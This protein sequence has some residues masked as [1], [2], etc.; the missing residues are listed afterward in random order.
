MTHWLSRTPLE[1]HQLGTRLAKILAP[2][3]TLLLE[4]ELGSGKT[5][6]VQGLAA[7]LGLD[8]QQVQSPTF[9]LIREHGSGD[10]RLIHVDLYRLEAS[11]TAALGLEEILVGPGVK[12][13]EW[14]ERLTFPV[15]GAVRLRLERNED[16]DRVIYREDEK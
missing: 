16:G 9:T 6:L 12:A 14:A 15:P 8:P 4:G 7:G 2:G 5:V 10:R 11:E 3:G 1:T 13:I